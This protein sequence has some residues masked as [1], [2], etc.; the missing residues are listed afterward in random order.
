MQATRGRT[1]DK[2]R[3]NIYYSTVCA[4]VRVVSR[5]LSRLVGLTTFF[6]TGLCA[7]ETLI[8]ENFAQSFSGFDADSDKVSL[9][10]ERPRLMENDS[11]IIIRWHE[12]LYTLEESTPLGANFEIQIS[13][14][15]LVNLTQLFAT[16]PREHVYNAR[17]GQKVHA[18]RHI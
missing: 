16:F 1:T 13:P 12:P 4:R 6:D 14:A 15:K 3:Q 5:S 11:M 9:A 18:L 8:R 7:G 17:A 2:E 10:R